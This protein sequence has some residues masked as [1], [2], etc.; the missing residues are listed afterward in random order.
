MAFVGTT[1]FS[2]Y[3]PTSPAWKST[4]TFNSA[5]EYFDYL[6][7]PERIEPR[8]RILS[9]FSMPLI[10]IAAEKHPIRHLIRYSTEMPEKYIS[11]LKEISSKYDLSS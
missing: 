6:Y 10:S 7:A 9:K 5:K 2:I 11:Q 1:R 3:D 4:S 8:L